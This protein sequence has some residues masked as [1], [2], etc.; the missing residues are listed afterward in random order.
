MGRSQLLLTLPRG[1]GFA[2]DLMGQRA[3]SRVDREGNPTPSSGS[4]D[5]LAPRFSSAVRDDVS[6]AVYTNTG[7][8]GLVRAPTRMYLVPQ[9]GTPGPSLAGPSA[10][11]TS[12]LFDSLDRPD[13]PN[14]NRNN[15]GVR[16]EPDRMPE[17]SL[18]L[19]ALALYLP[20]L[21]LRQ[22]AHGKVRPLPHAERLRGALLF[23][24]ITGFTQ[25]TQQLQA[26]ELGPARGAEELNKILSDYFDL[27]I[28]C[29]HAHGGDVV[30]FSG[31]AMTV[32]FEAV[33]GETAARLEAAAEVDV[34]A[35]RGSKASSTDG[36]VGAGGP[37]AAVAVCCGHTLHGST[38]SAPLGLLEHPAVIVKESSVREST[39]SR[40]PSTCSVRISV[41]KS[42]SPSVTGRLSVEAR[43]PLEN[44][45][46]SVAKSNSPAARSSVES[47]R[48][49]VEHSRL[50]VGTSSH[51]AETGNSSQSSSARAGS[52]GHGTSS[53]LG[54]STI[55]SS[56]A[57]RLARATGRGS[58]G[59]GS[60]GGSARRSTES[61][62][63]GTLAEGAC[64]SPAG[65]SP[66]AAS[67]RTL[68]T[69]PTLPSSLAHASDSSGAEGHDN[70]FAGLVSL[71]GF[72]GSRRPSP[73]PTPGDTPSPSDNAAPLN[74]PGSTVPSAS[75]R[76]PTPAKNSRPS[77]PRRS[78][79]SSRPALSI[80]APLSPGLPPSGAAASGASSGAA[81]APMTLTPAAIV[82]PPAAIGVTSAAI[83]APSD[84]SLASGGGEGGSGSAPRWSPAAVSGGDPKR[85]A[86]V[87][88]SLRAAQCALDVLEKVNGF[89]LAR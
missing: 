7:V 57:S 30:S 26:S 12:W 53:N 61:V 15:R 42:N 13:G 22:F 37:V 74:D 16:G 85:A 58:T 82:L 80:S 70:P 45:R 14:A 20:E 17:P 79:L 83:G 47:A 48:L 36:D 81:P 72:W 19:E 24:D 9:A 54:S 44:S 5:S 38:S 76:S 87:R 43:L 31:D 4:G 25:L 41:E 33:E 64:A 40:E 3:S 52:P 71:F 86:L 55:R 73:Q 1:G 60:A 69:P 78:S 50:S 77:S 63:T 75:L 32:L 62:D 88:A 65:S 6:D 27:L 39:V 28:R 11:R 84:D 21:V 46:L 59:G 66:A 10:G 35:A 49:P 67:A 8:M 51:L 29:F 56:S 23:A 68:A 89:S 2:R 18:A 34:A